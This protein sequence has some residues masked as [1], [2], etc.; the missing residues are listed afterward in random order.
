MISI[1]SEHINSDMKFHLLCSGSLQACKNAALKGEESKFEQY[2]LMVGD[3]F[4]SDDTDRMNTYLHR[5]KVLE[6]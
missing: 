3:R 1:F 5:I 6:H 4:S 2:K